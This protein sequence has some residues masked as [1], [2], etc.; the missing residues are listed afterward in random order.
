QPEKSVVFR[1]YLNCVNL[2][3]RFA[4]MSLLQL[5]EIPY[6]AVNGLWYDP[7]RLCGERNGGLWNRVMYITWGHRQTKNDTVVAVQSLMGEVVLPLRLPRAFHMSG[8]G[9][10]PA[11]PLF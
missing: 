9:I 8:L 6:N 11:D 1:H 7:R 3:N 4:N 5:L 10:C 2:C